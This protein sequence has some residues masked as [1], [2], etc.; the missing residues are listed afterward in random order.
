MMRGLLS[1]H[2][3]DRGGLCHESG[4]VLLNKLKVERPI[5]END[6][7]A[8]QLVRDGSCNFRIT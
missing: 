8:L 6:L 2:H 3:P 7:T 5:R 1:R 4:C